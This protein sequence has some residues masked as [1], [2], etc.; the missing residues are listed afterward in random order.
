MI[1]FSCF[2]AL[3]NARIPITIPIIIAIRRPQKLS[4]DE[5]VEVLVVI[6]LTVGLGRNRKGLEAEE[7]R[8]N[9]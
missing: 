8:F 3:H 9:G 4:S 6:G 2:Y 7:L 1:F 5:F